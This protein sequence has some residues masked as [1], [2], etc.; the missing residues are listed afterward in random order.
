MGTRSLAEKLGFAPETR[1]VIAHQDDVGMCHGANQAFAALAGQGFIGSGSVM[2]PC[3]WFL[4]LAELAAQ[5]PA[6]DIGVHLTLTSEWR[7]Y[8]WRPL[9]GASKS[10]GLV[11]DEGYMWHQARQVAEHAAP[12]AVEAELRAQMDAA[13]AAG[14]D[15]T[16]IDHHMGTALVPEFVDI[17]LKLARD[18]GLPVLFPR[19]WGGFGGPAALRLGDI[20]AE[21]HDR[22]VQALEA[23]GQPIIDRFI[24][25]HWEP[26]ADKAPIYR[27]MLAGIEPG[28]TFLAFHCNAS[29]DIEVIDPPRAHTR[30]D[31]V[32][33]F[34]DPAFLAWVGA[35]DLELVG[36]RAIREV[37]R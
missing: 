11:D 35:Q 21:A 12:D 3:P 6:L 36:F 20:A 34:Q 26:A 33:L 23:A 32:A 31:E 22:R 15:V 28:V 1:L 37:C 14:I 2:V 30:T 18:Y 8:R 13:L 5:R 24:E 25:S 9:T 4:E 29:G 17:T 10:S 19:Q 7:H 27:A 16:H